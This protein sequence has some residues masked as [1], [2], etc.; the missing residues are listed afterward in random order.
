MVEATTPNGGMRAQ[1]TLSLLSRLLLIL[2]MLSA[3][4]STNTKWRSMKETQQENLQEGGNKSHL[5]QWLS[6]LQAGKKN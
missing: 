6:G 2:L 4:F 5:A 3:A 1:L